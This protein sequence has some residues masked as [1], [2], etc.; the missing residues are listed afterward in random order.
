[1]ARFLREGCMQ[2]TLRELT[3]ESWHE[4][5][6]LRVAEDQRAYIASNLASLA[7]AHFYPGTIVR[8]VYADAT[9]VGFVMYG[10]DAE[11]AP[12]EE[13]GAY[14]LVR[15]MIDQAHQG[16]GYGRQ[17]LEAVIAE[18]GQQTGCPAIYTS[19]SPENQRALALYA[20]AGF[21]PTGRM[22]DGELVLRRGRR[23]G[24]EKARLPETIPT[25]TQEQ[26]IRDMFHYRMRVSE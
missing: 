4:C 7:E 8:A 6:D 21:E 25:E 22:L 12:A 15:L 13:P 18:L 9:M 14:A 19:T 16:E 26:G 17:A 5:V 24:D 2:V 23:L 20:R 1:M 3:A 10:P 11:Y